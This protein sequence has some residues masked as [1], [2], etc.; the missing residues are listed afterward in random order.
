M[1]DMFK[2]DLRQLWLFLLYVSNSRIDDIGAWEPAKIYARTAS[3]A[4]RDTTG[5][6]F[7]AEHAS[8]QSSWPHHMGGGM[9]AGGKE[10]QRE[11]RGGYLTKTH[12]SEVKQKPL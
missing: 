10:R 5:E 9:R 3:Q 7:C 8:A 12:L 2:L 4:L 6:T 1:Y 11:G